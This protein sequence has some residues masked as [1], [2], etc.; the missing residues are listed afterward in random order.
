MTDQM[1]TVL[2]ISGVGTGL[3][4]VALA[5]LIGLMYLLTS[6]TL[7]RPAAVAADA[8]TDTRNKTAD[9]DGVQKRN[10]VDE[11]RDRQRRAVA[12]AVATACARAERAPMLLTSVSSGWRRLH[13]SRRLSQPKS[14]AR[15]RIQR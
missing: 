11:E 15:T 3:L 4:F 5:G 7:F 2:L 6:Q 10:D 9:A 12:I 8:A 1:G 14:R 13:H